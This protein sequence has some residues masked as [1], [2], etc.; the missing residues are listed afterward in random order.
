MTLLVSHGDAYHNFKYPTKMLPVWHQ[1]TEKAAFC[2]KKCSGV[3]L[4]REQTS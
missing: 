1:Y 3:F 4:V 2:D